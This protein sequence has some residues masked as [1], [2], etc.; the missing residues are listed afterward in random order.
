MLRSLGVFARLRGPSA[1]RLGRPWAAG[2]NEKGADVKFWPLDKR[3]YI[4]LGLTIFVLIQLGAGRVDPERPIVGYTLGVG[5]L[6]ALFWLTEAIPLAVTALFPIVLFP[7]FGIMKGRDVAPLYLNNI[8]FLL[9]GGFIIALAMERWN[10]HKRIALSVILTIGCSPTRLLLGFMVGSWLLSMWVSNTATTLMMVPIVVALLIKIQENGA[11]NIRPLELSLL[12]GI[13]YAASIGGMAT[14]IGTAPNLSLARIHSITFPDA[15]P[16]TFVYWLT[17]GLPVSAVLLVV[18]FLLLRFMFTRGFAVDLD[19]G[20][21]RD[22]Y[23]ALGKPTYEERVV[24]FAFITFALLLITRADVTVGSRVIRGWGSLF[25]E[26]SFI[27]DGTT[28]I[29][30]ALLLFIIPTRSRRGFIMDGTT[31]GKLPWDIVILLGGGFALAKGFQDSGLS[32][33]LGGKLGALAGLHPIFMVLAVTAMITFL[34]ELTSN[35]ATTQVVL[36]IIA[37][38]STVVGVN[39]LVLM[40]PATVAASCAFMLP[41]ATPPNA[42]VFGTHRLRIQ[43][44]ARVGIWLNLISIVVIT[45]MIYLLGYFRF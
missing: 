29:A 14:L 32:A 5:V 7:A 8:L 37:S 10:L 1:R 20:V 4:V 31:I 26:S 16:I 11:K 18:S 28:S 42:I 6:M 45:V 36:P 25:G 27:D 22:E 3:W 34:T 2:S 43:E 41:V 9:M 15:E 39:P 13:A 40:V 33:Y 12:L 23:K 30:V 19:A 35:T 38:L 44:M 24:F 21:I 17:L